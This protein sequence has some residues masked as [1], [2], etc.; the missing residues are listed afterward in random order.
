MFLSTGHLSDGRSSPGGCQLVG[1]AANLTF[2]SACRLLLLLSFIMLQDSHSIN[3]RPHIQIKT[4]KKYTRPNIHRSPFLLLLS[5]RLILISCPSESD[6]GMVSRHRHCS[7][8]RKLLI[9][10]SCDYIKKLHIVYPML[11]KPTL[12][13]RKN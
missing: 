11:Y 9:A 3:N 2:E 7:N 1:Q 5:I 6:G 4:V 8:C 10:F 12:K 13:N